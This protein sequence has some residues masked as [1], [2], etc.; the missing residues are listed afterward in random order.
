LKKRTLA[1]IACLG[2]ISL[3]F[4]GV[5]WAGWNSNWLVNA[6][7]A[8][9]V[10]GRGPGRDAVEYGLWFQFPRYMEGISMFAF[11]LFLALWDL[12]SKP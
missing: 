8:G 1:G 6:I 11:F 7:N 12:W 9:T 3:A 5:L 10:P 4:I 2:S